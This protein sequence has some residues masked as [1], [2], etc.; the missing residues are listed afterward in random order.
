MGTL[1]CVVCLRHCMMAMLKGKP[2]ALGAHSTFAFDLER[3]AVATS[4]GRQ[5][6][7]ALGRPLAGQVKPQGICRRRVPDS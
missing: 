7:V 1:V 4:V 5:D 3:A 6:A 2:N